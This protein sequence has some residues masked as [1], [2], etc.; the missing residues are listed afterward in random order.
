MAEDR[1]W[2]SSM[3]PFVGPAEKNDENAIK[4]IIYHDAALAQYIESFPLDTDYPI[5][6]ARFHPLRVI[7]ENNFNFVYG[8]VGTGKSQREI[9][10]AG[11]L[12]IK[13]KEGKAN[14]W[15]N[16][17][18]T[19]YLVSNP[20]R[21]IAIFPHGLKDLTIGKI[22]NRIEAIKTASN[23]IG[24]DTNLFMIA[25]KA[26]MDA[27]YAI[28][29]P[30]RTTQQSGKTN[31]GITRTTLRSSLNA[32]LTMQWGDLGLEIN[33]FRDDPDSEAKIKSFHNLVEIQQTAQKVFN[34]TLKALKSMFLAKRTM[35][36]SSK[37][38]IGATGGNVMVYLATTEGG[39]DSTGVPVT[40]GHTLTFTASLFGITDYGTHCYITVV[41]QSGVKVSFLLQLY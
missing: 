30:D 4:Q 27:E 17:T 15:Y 11:L 24:A 13:G 20:A 38:R 3:S 7:A 36:G 31:K 33:K 9:V 1:N 6:Y 25:I 19:V 29:K 2:F 12:A 16:R 8:A 39:T 21:V 18:K 5:W 23:Q 14:D 22:D 28:L 41:N 34:P 26:E 40:N 37:L 35:I 32:A 10:T